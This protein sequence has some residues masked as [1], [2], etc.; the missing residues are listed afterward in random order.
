MKV[1]DVTYAM[2]SDR[3]RFLRTGAMTIA[4]ARLALSGPLRAAGASGSPSANQRTP[5]ELAAIGN[6]AEWVNSPRLTS[7]SL[8]GRV[9]LVDFWTYTCINW[10]RTLPH[11]RAWAR[12]Y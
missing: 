9:V 12:K 4:A 3:R 5:R 6:A 8:A 7:S 10:L 1:A 2:H 11:V